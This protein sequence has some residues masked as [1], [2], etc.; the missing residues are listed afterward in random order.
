MTNGSLRRIAG[1]VTSCLYTYV[2]LGPGVRTVWSVS[3]CP[4]V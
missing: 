3:V 1:Q 2:R 4:A